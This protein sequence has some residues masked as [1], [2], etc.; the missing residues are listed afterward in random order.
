MSRDAFLMEEITQLIYVLF[1]QL[2]DQFLLVVFKK[3]NW[4]VLKKRTSKRRG[5]N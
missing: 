3:M 4:I 2:L 1:T 5:S